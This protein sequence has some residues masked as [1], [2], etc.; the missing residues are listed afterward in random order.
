VAFALT[1]TFVTLAISATLARLLV[2]IASIGA[3]PLLRKLA[4]TKAL[5]PPLAGGALVANSLCVWAS[6]QSN[7]KQ[8]ALIAASISAGTIL[9]FIARYSPAAAQES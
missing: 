1:G 6:L 2:Y 4:G 7:G 9:F 8:W 5:T 3:L